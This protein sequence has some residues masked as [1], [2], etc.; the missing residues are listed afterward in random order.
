MTHIQ[1]MIRGAVLV[2]GLA[3]KFLA[4]K[5]GKD[6]AWKAGQ[7]VVK[8]GA[9]AGIDRVVKDPYEAEKWK[10]R[11]DLTVRL[12]GG[13]RRGVVDARSARYMSAG[14]LARQGGKQYMERMG[15]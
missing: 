5:I 8:S 9:K 11:A 3:G 2:G 13:V 1:L 4:T 7:E 15:K 6:I 10:G 12:A 14:D